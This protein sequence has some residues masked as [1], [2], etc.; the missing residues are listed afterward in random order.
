MVR[1]T[2][3]IEH[4]A[5]ATSF[6]VVGLFV[7]FLQFLVFVVFWPINKDVYR[8]LVNTL[9]FSHWSI[10]SWIGFHYSGS[11]LRVYCSDEDLP[12]IGKEA[13]ILI[14]NH[15]YSLDFLTTVMIPDQFGALGMFKAMQKKSIKYYPVIGWDFWF[16]ENIFLARNAAKDIATIENDIERLANSQVPFWMTLYAEGTRFTKAKHEAAEEIAKDKGYKPLKHHLQPRPTGFVTIIKKLRENKG[17]PV[18]IYDM[19]IQQTNN[20]N[21]SMMDLLNLRPT[22]FTVYIRRIPIS[23]VPVDQESTWLREN[24]QQKDKR[25]ESMLTG[26]EEQLEGVKLQNLPVPTASKVVANIWFM[27]LLPMII[28]PWVTWTYTSLITTGLSLTTCFAIMLPI[29]TVMLTG[30]IIRTG[31]MKSSSSYGLKK[32][33]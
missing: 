24:Y 11:G 3:P 20:E 23:D 32:K 31:D 16:C 15:R 22:E 1:W 27:I 14:P 17:Q 30:A 18:M 12:Y 9:Q 28:Y 8:R 7:N 21:K 13:A 6:I 4:L 10:V 19:T 2:L 33:Q 26:N 5:I 25:F 29:A